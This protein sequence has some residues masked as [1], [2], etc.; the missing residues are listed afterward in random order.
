MS[1]QASIN[2]IW[3]ISLLP[4]REARQQAR[5]F[6]VIQVGFPYTCC[7]PGLKIKK[8]LLSAYYVQEAFAVH[9]SN[10]QQTCP[11]DSYALTFH[12][13]VLSHCKIL[14]IPY[15]GDFY[16]KL[17]GKRLN[18][19]FF[20]VPLIFGLKK[21]MQFI[22]QQ[23]NYLF[24]CLF[25]R[26]YGLLACRFKSSFYHS[27]SHVTLLHLLPVFKKFTWGIVLSP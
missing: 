20:S 19:H 6:P 24:I 3:I 26:D 1:A 27:A 17:S 4:K 22:L 11:D 21:N 15:P 18:T 7:A 2:N 13:L 25:L 8:Y 16:D 12:P 14:K 23:Y 5:E 9:G 10:R